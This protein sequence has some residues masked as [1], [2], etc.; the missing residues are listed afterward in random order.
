M[1]AALRRQEP[2]HVPFWS[3][4]RNKDVPFR[5][6]DQVERAEGVLSLG[7][8]DTL[9]LQPPLRKT[10]HYDANQVPG[11]VRRVQKTQQ[12][13]EPYPLLFKEYETPAGTLR[14]VVRQTE[15][16]PFGDDLRLFSDHNISRSIEFPV[17]GPA[18]LEPL[19][20]LLCEPT[21]DQ[22]EAFRAEAAYLRKQAERLGVLFEGGWTTLGDAALW[23]VGTEALLYQQ[24]DNPELIEELLEMVCRWEMRRMELLLEEKVQAIVHSA[25][26][27][28]TDFWTPRTF[29][30]M[31]LPRLQ[32]LAN[33]AHQGGAFF[34]YIV[35]TSCPSL[36]DALLESGVDSIMGVDPVQGSAD[37]TETKRRLGGRMCLWGGINSAV[38]LEQG[39]D[40]EIRAATESGIRRL[41]PGGGFVLYPVDQL[42]KNLP[43]NKVQ[44]M[45]DVW[46]ELGSYPMQEAKG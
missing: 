2:D 37:L 6:G 10:E 46:R 23:L 34:N 18:D 45:L 3:L 32:A 7:L 4:W 9:L 17:K 28:T 12:A 41:G 24:M 20:H 26:Y 39:S 27:E 44:V 25:W 38:T 14:Q 21:R 29:R 8:D 40:E 30:R 42:G 19:R 43:W 36:F 16:W 13:G 35:T 31:L 22:I 33:L 5:Y 11:V 15:D 1:L